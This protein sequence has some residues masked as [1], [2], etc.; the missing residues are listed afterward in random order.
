MIHNFEFHPI[1]ARGPGE[2]IIP[3]EIPFSLS[4]RFAKSELKHLVKL[5]YYV[6]AEDSVEESLK[7][8]SSIFTS[9]PS[10]K[11]GCSGSAA[12]T[13]P[14]DKKDTGLTQVVLDLP[15]LD[16]PVLDL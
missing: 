4:S 5:T 7:F 9:C 8:W 3:L 15:V 16:L 14:R 11:I 1:S 13:W 6:D 2:I 12:L 10:K